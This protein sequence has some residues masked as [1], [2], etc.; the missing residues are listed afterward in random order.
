MRLGAR[1]ILVVALVASAFGC[2]LPGVGPGPDRVL[3]QNDTD[4]AVGVYLNEAW[5]GTYP[6]GAT[7]TIPLV[8]HR[9]PPFAVSVRTAAGE[10]LLEETISAEDMRRARE[11]GFGW[12]SGSSG[13]SQPCGSIRLTFGDVEQLEDDIEPEPCR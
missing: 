5:V 6:A 2:E 12:S 4:V 9:G 11:E 13:S 7:A 8:G 1:I 10:G 3:L